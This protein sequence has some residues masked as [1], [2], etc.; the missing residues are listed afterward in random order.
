MSIFENPAR[1]RWSL[2]RFA[3]ALR[4]RRTARLLDDISDSQLKDIGLSR[5]D[6]RRVIRGR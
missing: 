2:A 3:A 5:S 4:A 1:R 6:I